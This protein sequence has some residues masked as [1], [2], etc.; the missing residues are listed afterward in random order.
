MKSTWVIVGAISVALLSSGCKGGGGGLF[1]LFSGSDSAGDVL[2]SFS[3]GGGDGG[4]SPVGDLPGGGGG[5]PL[6]A[7]LSNPE[8]GS[9]ALFGGG[10]A[11][12]GLWRRRRSRA[13]RKSVV[14]S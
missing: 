6:V 1:S 4:G 12:L 10:L 8:P 13:K 14:S 2:N 7:S 11:G 9:I 5:A 3:P